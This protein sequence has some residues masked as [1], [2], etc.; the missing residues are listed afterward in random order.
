MS[1]EA[2]IWAGSLPIGSCS[3][4][5]FRVLLKYADR[6]DQYGR[7]A[8]YPASKLA[9]ELECSDRTV[10]RAIKELVDLG[11]MSVGDQGFVS[12]IPANYRPIVYDLETPAKQMQ[13][14]LARGDKYAALDDSGVTGQSVR[15][16]N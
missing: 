15:G 9:A 11:L 2:Y 13:D 3:G 6:V 8:W 5:A 12:H 1:L 16:D 7:T 4:A 10:R 14:Y